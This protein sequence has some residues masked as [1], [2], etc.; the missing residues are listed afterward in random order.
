M[1]YSGAG[2]ASRNS[3]SASPWVR[4]FSIFDALTPFRTPWSRPAGDPLPLAYLDSP[5]T[6]SFAGLDIDLEVL[7]QTA[8]MRERNEAPQRLSRSNFKH[9]YW[10]V[11]QLVTH[12]TVSGCNLQAGDLLGSGT[13]S[14]PAPAEAGSLLELSNGGRKPLALNNGKQ[15]TFLEDGDTVVLRAWADKAGF[16]RI[17]FGE[18][19]GTIAEAVRRESNSR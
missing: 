19:S 3:A 9:S 6:R 12:H 7:L 4:R 15:R 14:G 10:S 5:A 16:A 13:Q 18:A 11:S 17:G 8:Q 2:A 1:A